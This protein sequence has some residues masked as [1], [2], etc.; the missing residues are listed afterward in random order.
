MASPPGWEKRNRKRKKATEERILD[1]C[2]SPGAYIHDPHLVTV[3][4]GTLSSE[5]FVIDDTADTI[6]PKE[7]FLPIF[8]SNGSLVIGQEQDLLRSGGYGF[9]EEQAFSGKLTQVLDQFKTKA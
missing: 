4:A 1:I 3:Y 8:H 6:I 2:L 9:D 5:D 7:E